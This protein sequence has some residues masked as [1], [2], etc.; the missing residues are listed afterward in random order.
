MPSEGGTTFLLF[1]CFYQPG[2]NWVFQ[3]LWLAHSHTPPAPPRAPILHLPI[4]VPEAQ[5]T[6]IVQPSG[7]VLLVAHR[8]VDGNICE[9]PEGDSCWPRRS[10]QHP[11]FGG[12]PRCVRGKQSQRAKSTRWFYPAGVRMVLFGSPNQAREHRLKHHPKANTWP[13]EPSAPHTDDELCKHF[14]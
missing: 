11:A 6:F 5:H 7:S 3:A 13:Y 2:R 9:L 12:A 1:S 10:A 8:P 4:R 14:T